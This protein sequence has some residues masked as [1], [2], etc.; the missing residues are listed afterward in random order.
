M[1][2][3]IFFIFSLLI[4]KSYANI[5]F[6][7]CVGDMSLPSGPAGYACKHPAKLTVDDFVYSGLNIPGTVSKIL[8]FN[9]SNAFAAEFPALNG[10]G[11]SATRVDIDVGG[12]FPA[13][14]HRVSELFII[15]KGT[16][17]AGFIDTNN[18]PFY[19]TLKKG[20]IMI[21]PPSLLHFV[22]NV[23]STPVTA[24]A[25]FASENPGVQLIDTAL[26]RNNLPSELVEKITL[27]DHKQVQ[28]LKKVF[29]G[30]N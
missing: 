21:F 24:Y 3:P 30:T 28:K 11:I 25:S 1:I 10:M 29:G 22:V 27:L 20:D 2:I 17:I 5:P 7:Y 13:H 6:D 23:G 18:T 26:F 4:H 15:I 12:F 19:K 16:I 14:A 8:K 9:A